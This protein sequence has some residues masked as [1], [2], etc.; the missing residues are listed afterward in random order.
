M[1]HFE[2]LF[3]IGDINLLMSEGF[4]PHPRFQFSSALSLGIESEC[5]ILEFL[6]AEEYS[7]E[8]LE[9]RLKISTTSKMGRKNHAD[10]KIKRIRRCT[11]AK[12]VSLFNN[13]AMTQYLLPYDTSFES[14]VSQDIQNFEKMEKLI[15]TDERGE[16]DLKSFISVENT[17]VGV[18]LFVKQLDA[19]PKI[20]ILI[21]Q[22]FEDVEFSAV[23]KQMMYKDLQRNELFYLD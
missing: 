22:I 16:Y 2:T 21:S 23:I 14:K 8:D 9:S 10:L 1:R 11:N 3:R 19:S 12:K 18:K 4:N 17:D 15:Y 20:R 5:E 13:L 6:T 7:V